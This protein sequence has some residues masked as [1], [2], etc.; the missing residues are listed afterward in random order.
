MTSETNDSFELMWRAV[1]SRS[2]DADGTFV[3]AV[4]TTVVFCHP[5]CPSR[6]PRRENVAF[7]EAARAAIAAGFRPCQRCRSELLPPRIRHAA[8]VVEWCRLL[9]QEPPASL[10]TLAAHAGL[11]LHHVHKSFRAATGLTPQ[12]WARARRRDRLAAA[13]QTEPT[14]T[15]AWVKAGYSSAG[16]FY[17]GDGA[18]LGMAPRAA[19][20]GGAGV[21]LQVACAPCALGIALVAATAKGVCAI[22]LGDDPRTLED[23][24]QRRFPQAVK[25]EADAAFDALVA[26]AIAAVDEP[27][28]A[29][30]LL[31]DIIGTTFQARVWQALRAIPLGQTTTYGALAAAIGSPTAVR[32]VAGACARNPIAVAVPC[33]RVLGSDGS[34]T[35]YRWGI[36]RKESL[37][38]REEA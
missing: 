21:I 14:V 25:R 13:L 36:A 4:A 35:G 7:F 17:D 29:A 15:G 5:S 19:S 20:R 9:E 3:Y 30:A 24:L 2:A 22:L 28:L 6:R 27:R 33:H 1:L 31:V 11:S 26:A 32:A 34:H 38:A 16:R 37:L 23:D 12:G 18:A 10:S 8:L